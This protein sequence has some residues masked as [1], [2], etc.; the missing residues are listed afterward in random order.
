MGGWGIIPENSDK[1]AA[2]ATRTMNLTTGSL[3]R[4][5]LFFSIPLM[6]SNLLQILFNM[7][8]IAV[9]GQFAADGTRALG[10]V[11]ST[12]T[13][14][15]LFTGFLI[16]IAGGV[17]VLVARCCGAHDRKGAE[18]AIHTSAILC[19]GAGLLLL[20][21]GQ[22]LARPLLEL[23]GTKP[24]LIDGATLYLRIYFCGMPALA[25][26]NFG[27]AVY[28]AVGNTK[29]PLFYLTLAGV[30]NVLF[31]LLTVIA[32]S[33]DV[34]GVALASVVAQYVSAA[35]VVISLMRT[36]EM[37]GLRLRA[38]RI[39]PET[40]RRVLGL[41][42][43]SGMQNA[44]FHIANLFIQAAV[45]SFDT[46][47]VSGN[48]AAAN[49]DGLVYDVMAAFYT[50]C[51]SFMSQNYGAGN[52]ERVIR[53]YRISLLYSATVG[54]LLGGGL[55]LL[56]RPFLG[57][58]A[59]DP[60]VVEAG[61]MR[62]RIMGLSYFMSAFMDCTIA[63]SRG[64]GKTIWPTGLV[65]LGSCVF[66]ILWIY[67]VFAHF[68]TVASLYLL[69]IFSWSLTAL[70]EIIYFAV[71]Y[72]RIARGMERCAPTRAPTQASA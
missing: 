35:L 11:G 44:I 50:A 68:G 2:M 13:M 14:V 55:V 27:N 39:H 9:V 4:Q 21:V 49:A 64:L 28:S 30:I 65:I 16:G 33:M 62:L 46:V 53:S 5:I 10:A 47:M 40:A 20:L 66:R 57:L 43:P 60:A 24:D 70:A 12:T 37:H 17:N 63:A 51:S 7:A 72:R 67:T 52:R 48:A 71:I 69:Y 45:N 18:E 26:F 3:P 25:I 36:K 8:D 29:R 32:L 61:M 19:L 23:L 31:N 38:L 42:V 15:M 1:G 54:A 58:F 56:G 34:A 6:L 41:G 59:T 22:L